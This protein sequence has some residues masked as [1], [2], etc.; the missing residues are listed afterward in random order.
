M[1]DTCSH[2]DAVSVFDVP[3]RANVPGC[4]ECLK[5]GG[6]WVHLRIC[7]MCGKVGCCDSSPNK[8]ASKHAVGDDHPIMTSIEPGEDWSWCVIDEVG[9]VLE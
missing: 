8:H 3:T 2:I 1:S 5:I 7:R 9:F 4:E 6:T